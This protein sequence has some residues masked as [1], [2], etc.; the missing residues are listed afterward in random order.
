MLKCAPLLQSSINRDANF[1]DFPTAMFTLFRMTTG[2]NWNQLMVDS[3]VMEDCIVVEASYNFT[4]TAGA[5]ATLIWA[6]TYLDPVRDAV[7]ISALPSDIK[8]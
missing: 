4:L 1:Q 5:N 3:M 2:E 8:V 7:T 6:G